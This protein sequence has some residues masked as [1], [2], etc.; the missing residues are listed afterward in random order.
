MEIDFWRIVWL[1]GAAIA[2]TSVVMGI[3]IFVRG[4]MDPAH[5]VIVTVN[6]YHEMW[7]EVPLMIA[8]WACILLTVL[9]AMFRGEVL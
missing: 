7:V 6:D 3:L 2:V 5:R 4:W 1:L 8:G 9:R